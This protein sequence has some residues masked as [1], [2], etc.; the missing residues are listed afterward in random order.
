MNGFQ[1]DF[2]KFSE[3]YFHNGS[4]TI[5]EKWWF[6]YNSPM[7]RAVYPSLGSSRRRKKNCEGYKKDAEKNIKSTRHATEK[8]SVYSSRPE[9]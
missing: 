8:K 4:N 6:Y 7:T 2:Q 5:K 3:K 1:I 9:H